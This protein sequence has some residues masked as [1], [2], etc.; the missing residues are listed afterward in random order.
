MR[1][2]LEYE[3]KNRIIYGKEICF[4]TKVRDFMCLAS[5]KLKMESM[6]TSQL[7]RGVMLV[8]LG[9]LDDV[10]LFRRDLA[11]KKITNF[12]SM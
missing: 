7:V 9:R 5:M 4:P 8:P 12:C 1:Q 11:P 6:S 3:T 10:A 2:K